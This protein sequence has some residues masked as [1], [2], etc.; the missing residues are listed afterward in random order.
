MITPLR[1]IALINSL[2]DIFSIVFIICLF[3][4]IWGFHQE[5]PIRKVPCMRCKDPLIT[6]TD[7]THRL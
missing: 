4:L 5:H 3:F 1:D 6:G 2:M 7:E